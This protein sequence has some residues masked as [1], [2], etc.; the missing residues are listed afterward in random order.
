MQSTELLHR[1]FDEGLDDALEDVLFERMAVDAELRQ[2]FLQHQKLHHMIQEDVAGITTP[3]HVSQQLFINLGLTPPANTSTQPAGIGKRMGAAAALVGN[4]L[5]KG[6]RYVFTA[7]ISAL[8]TAVLV[9]SISPDQDVPVQQA[10]VTD[11]PAATTISPQVTPQH[12]ETEDGVSATPGTA[13]PSSLSSSA[14]AGGHRSDLLQSR[15][16]NTRSSAGRGIS[17]AGVSAADALRG[18]G[19]AVPVTLAALPDPASLVT[20][21]DA[22]IS[23]AGIPLRGNLSGAGM[24]DEA[25]LQA[26]VARTTPQELPS[27]EGDRPW[28]FFQPGP[29]TNILSNMVFEL[30][31]V[32]GQSYPT[33]DLPHN[34]HNLFENMAISAV[35]K[36]TDHHAFGFEYGREAFGREYVTL[37][38]PTAPKLDGSMQEIYTPPSP[39]MAEQVRENRMVDVIGAVWKLSM[40]EYGMFRFVYPYMR[41]FVGASLLGPV[42][43]VRVGLEMFPSNYS[44]LN[45]GLEG[46]LLR[47]S[48]DESVYYTSKL[49]FTV[50]VAIGF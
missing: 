26:L 45:V 31:K 14:A 7:A 24:D 25:A 33:V 37:G 5:I 21:R 43:K 44:M 19:S 35:Y 47:Y 49:N 17:T 18:D 6:R 46:G 29:R 2:E 15:S 50:G 23:G 39:A 28:H 34:S 27:T 1:F 16:S 12:T 40:P 10:K 9:L 32:Y 30:R 22:E 13:V 11:T 4:A 38:A 41:T 48:V 36:V 8:A 3:S 20:R 42:S